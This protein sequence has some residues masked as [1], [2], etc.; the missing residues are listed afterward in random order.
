MF[1][2]LKIS[3]LKEKLVN[4]IIEKLFLSKYGHLSL[5]KVKK[6]DKKFHKAMAKCPF[7]YTLFCNLPFVVIC[8]IAI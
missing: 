3:V 7:L 6:R 4:S 8:S 1:K 2:I 5:Q